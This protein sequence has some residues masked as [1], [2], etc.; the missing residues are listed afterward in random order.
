ML[1]AT[2]ALLGVKPPIRVD[3]A[4]KA[5]Q[6][7]GPAVGGGLP[8]V[9][10]GVHRIGRETRS[11]ASLGRARSCALRALSRQDRVGTLFAHRKGSLSGAWPR[12]DAPARGPSYR[13]VLQLR[14]LTSMGHTSG[15]MAEWVWQWEED[16]TRPTRRPA[17]GWNSF[18]PGTRCC[19]CSACLRATPEQSGERCRGGERRSPPG[20]ERPGAAGGRVPLARSARSIRDNELTSRGEDGD[21]ECLLRELGGVVAT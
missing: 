10:L 5:V 15:C 12:A 21:T 19:G 9:V 4:L 17:L 3:P 2:A 13:G 8:A 1:G 14:G 6:E 7:R 20:R 11:Q 18:L 16:R